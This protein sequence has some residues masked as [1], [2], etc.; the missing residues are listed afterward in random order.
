M[1]S[2]VRDLSWLPNSPPPAAMVRGERRDREAMAG[3][4]G[5]GLTKLQHLAAL[6][7]TYRWITADRCPQRIEID[8]GIGLPPQFVSHQWWPSHHARHYCN[9][10][11]S[12]LYRFYYGAEISVPENST[13]SSICSASSMALTASSTSILP[14]NLRRPVE[15]TNSLVAF[16][17]P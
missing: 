16:V 2:R 6:H 3:N 8:E 1:F 7:R 14:F 13:I 10:D 12:A 15:S 17:T 9:A 4:T 5:S 11:A